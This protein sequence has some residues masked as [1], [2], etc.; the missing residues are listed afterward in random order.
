[1]TPLRTILSNWL[2][3]DASTVVSTRATGS[4][5]LAAICLAAAIAVLGSSGGCKRS[6]STE[7]VSGKLTFRSEPLA[8]AV[9]TFYPPVGR[10]VPASVNQ[11]EYAAELAPGEYVVTLT[12][13][14]QFP[15]GFKEGDPL[16][17]PKVILPPEYTERSKSSL[18]ATVAPGQSDPINFDL[19]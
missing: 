17:P 14:P 13:A 8:N 19:K 16:P 4:H 5:N 3:V 1:M 12:L 6:A 10:A 15:P 18:K 11:G 7:S 9:I 2:M